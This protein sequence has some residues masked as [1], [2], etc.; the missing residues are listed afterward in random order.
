MAAALS[1]YLTWPLP[2]I[3]GLKSCQLR[4]A[5]FGALRNAFT[6][7]VEAMPLEPIDTKPFEQMLNDVAPGN[8][9]T[10]NVRV[11]SE[12]SPSTRV[13]GVA[14]EPTGSRAPAPASTRWLPGP[15]GIIVSTVLSRSK[16][17]EDEM[18]S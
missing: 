1:S 14:I 11:T 10:V 13:I 6:S 12:L 16:A 18:F 2:V 17:T 15:V 5:V 3:P 9:P 7:G 8:V 4:Q